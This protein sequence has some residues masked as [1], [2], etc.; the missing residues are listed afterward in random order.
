MS[1]SRPEHV[2]RDRELLDRN[3][4]EIALADAV[5]DSLTLADR[6]SR[7]IDCSTNHLSRP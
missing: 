3:V 7:P 1:S 2:G 4:E 5:L 6:L